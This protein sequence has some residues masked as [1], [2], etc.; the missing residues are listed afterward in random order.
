MLD[1]QMQIRLIDIACKLS[2]I[3][4]YIYHESHLP[5]MLE[6]LDKSYKALVKTVSEANE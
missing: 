6:R 3:D 5:E 1:P 2:D 4:K